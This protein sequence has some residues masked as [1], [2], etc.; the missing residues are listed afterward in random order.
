MASRLQAEALARTAATLGRRA[1][2]EKRDPRLP[3]IWFVT[4]P[5]RTPN[6]VSIAER[7]PR[8]AGVIYRAFGSPDAET[9]GRALAAVARRRG[10]MLL[11]GADPDL[12]R[13][14]GAS[15]VHLPERL[16][17]L[18]PRLRARRPDWLVTAAAHD[19][20]AVIAADRAGV[21]ALLVSPVFPSRSPSAT[22]P[23]G[24]PRA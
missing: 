24:P 19:A 12:A 1:G 3:D 23:L 6:P 9:V 20:R 15:G 16:A 22:H 2:R 18:A 17:Y 11:A 21:D 10:L 7:L 4:D 14:I 13:R 8:G 5:T